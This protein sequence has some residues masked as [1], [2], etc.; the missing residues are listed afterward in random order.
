MTITYAL[1]AACFLAT[2]WLGLR[3]RLWIGAVGVAALALAFPALVTVAAAL[4]DSLA[5]QPA[6]HWGRD[7]K[8]NLLV[9]GWALIPLWLIPLW[10]VPMLAGYL[11][12][13][14]FRAERSRGWRASVGPG[15]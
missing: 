8:A 9:T 13:L 4:I 5:G 14:V 2:L 3:R 10:L 6:P 15:A 11:I 1:L 7:V 12:G